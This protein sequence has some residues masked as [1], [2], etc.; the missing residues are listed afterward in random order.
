M[1]ELLFLVADKNM[2]EAVAGLLERDQVHRVIGCRPFSFDSRRDI[3]VAAGQNDPGLY[4]RANEL[5]RPLS[6]D[7]R[8]AVVIVDEEWEGSPGA[9]EIEAALRRHL[10]D[11]GWTEDRSLALVVCPEAD[12]WLWSDSPQSATALGW[13]S[14]NELRPALESK[15]WIA[16][17]ETKPARPKE[18]AEWALRNCGRRRVPR[19]AAL[20][21]Q[22]ASNA[23]VR[24]CEDSALEQ[25][26][27]ALQ[28]W[29]PLEGA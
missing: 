27:A 25:L 3:K 19:S 5:L 4:V 22:V 15:G 11:A 26:L 23:S 8:R 6:A 9:I 12:V 29:F 7:Y 18:A 20:Y 13:P 14:W 28:S 2:A 1:N 17:G 10:T 24:R 16:P 21:R